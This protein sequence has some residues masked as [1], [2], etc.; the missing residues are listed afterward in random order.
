MPYSRC[1]LGTVWTSIKPFSGSS[2]T[3]EG[4]A[5]TAT[6][7]QTEGKMKVRFNQTKEFCEELKKDADKVDRGIV[8]CSNLFENAKISP[9]IRYVTFVATYSIQGQIVELRDYC[10]DI[11]RMEQERD[12]KVY[13]KAKECYEA[14]EKTCD[15]LKLEIRGGCLETVSDAQAKV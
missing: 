10:G 1:K 13:D 8:R 3:A 14:V 9:N 15:R 2:E 11:W 5:G 6:K 7:R 12:Q 4:F